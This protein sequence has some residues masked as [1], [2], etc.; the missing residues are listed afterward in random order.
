MHASVSRGGPTQVKAGMEQNRLRVRVPS[1]QDVEH[2][3]HG[4]HGS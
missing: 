3:D 2:G 4:S 1:P